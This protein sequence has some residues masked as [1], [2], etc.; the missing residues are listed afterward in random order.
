MAL[1]YTKSLSA[2]IYILNE[3]IC[4]D[5]AYLSIDISAQIYYN[6]TIVMGNTGEGGREYREGKQEHHRRAG[7]DMV[8][9]PQ[10]AHIKPTAAGA[11]HKK[12]GGT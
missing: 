8:R 6:K 1:L 7:L 3:Y 10:E 4:A 12:R 9:R 11:A 2:Y 5:M